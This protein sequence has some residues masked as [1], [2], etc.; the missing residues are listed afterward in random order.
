[1]SE[2]AQ[3][4]TPSQ[5]RCCHIFPEALSTDRGLIA[6]TDSEECGVKYDA[7]IRMGVRDMAM[8]LVADD[9]K[10]MRMRCVA[11]VQELGHETVEACDGI[12]AIALYKRTQPQAVL[13]DI[14]MPKVDGLAALSE[15]MAFDPS[16]RVAMV[17]AV[18]QQAIA[19][20]A[21]QSGAK[22]L[23]VKPF[24]PD[25]LKATVQKLLLNGG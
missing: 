2:H 10:F 15:I 21:M 5:L 22:D 8:V 14:T 4:I 3:R 18:N 17:T 19:M 1:M 7:A 16:A 12:Q 9:S 6:D 20:Q 23:V 24:H 25:K 13:L 11:M